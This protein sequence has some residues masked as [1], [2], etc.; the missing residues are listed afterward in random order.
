MVSVRIVWRACITKDE[1]ICPPY[2]NEKN[3]V[4]KTDEHNEI[5]LEALEDYRRWFADDPGGADELDAIKIKE[6]DE[7]IEYVKGV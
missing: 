1:R 3:E 6:I 5:I 7:A 2:K 4:I